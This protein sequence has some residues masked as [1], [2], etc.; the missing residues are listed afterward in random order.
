MFKRL[1]IRVAVSLVALATHPSHANV[2]CAGAVGYLGLS[3]GG[4]VV[5]AAGTNII[6]ICNL[7]SQGSFAA[8]TATCRNVYGALV[9]A[10]LTG[11]S[12]TVYFNDPALTSCSQMAAWS[13]QPTFYFLEGPW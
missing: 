4:N 12:I 10:K 5:I 11:K 9:A 2:S 7:A 6:Q 3:D 1:A 13:I 8:T